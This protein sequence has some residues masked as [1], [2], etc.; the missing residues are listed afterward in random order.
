MIDVSC[1][2]C[3]TVYDSDEAHI[4]KQI[5]CTKCGTPV[6]NTPPT[7]G[8]IVRAVFRAATRSNNVSAHVQQR[9]GYFAIAVAVTGVVVVS[10]AL[11]RHPTRNDSVSVKTETPASTSKIPAFTSNGKTQQV[12]EP[13]RNELRPTAYHSLPTGTRIG[14][15]IGTNGHGEL[16]VENDAA[17]DAVVRLSDLATDQTSR[18]FF[19]KAHS[20]AH[21][22][23]IPEGKYRLTFTTGL[24]WIESDDTFTWEPDYFEFGQTFEYTEPRAS[25]GIH[26]RTVNITLHSVPFGNV[27]AKKI[28]RDQF[29]KGHRHVAL[30]TQ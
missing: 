6:P 13:I 19:V 8:S 3:D 5:R 22:Q 2:R 20:T 28:T 15:D 10:V 21:A 25:D 23:R 17:E 9:C 7:T 12:N 16:N 24:N 18:W 26:Y 14:G 30:Q 1:P 27:H 29:L 11:L 4:E